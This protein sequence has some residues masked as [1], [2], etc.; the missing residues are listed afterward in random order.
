[1]IDLKCGEGI[2]YL[3]IHKLDTALQSLW[4]RV[5]GQVVQI[6]SYKF[7]ETPDLRLV[8]GDRTEKSGIYC[9]LRKTRGGIR[10][11]LRLDK[12]SANCNFRDKLKFDPHIVDKKSKAEWMYLLLEPKDDLTECINDISWIYKHFVP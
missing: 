9:V 10:V 7:T 4:F 12:L 3:K 6:S 11:Y 5:I 2:E 8:K 1:M